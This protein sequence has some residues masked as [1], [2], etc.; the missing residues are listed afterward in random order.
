MFTQDALAGKHALICGASQGIGQAC[1]V[2]MARAGA[3]ITVLARQAAGLRET[4]AL[5]EGTRSEHRAVCCDTSELEQVQRAIKEI[6]PDVDILLCNSGGPAPGPLQTAE[7]AAL[8]Q[9]YRQ[10]V[11]G[12]TLFVQ[13]FAPHMR[14]MHY[15]RVIN[16]ISTSVKVPLPN[17]GVSNTVR[18]AVASWAK[19]LANELGPHGITVNNVLPGYTKTQ[20]LAQIVSNAVQK[21]GKTREAV[22]QGFLD[23]VPA[24]RFAEA[25]EIAAACTF[26]ASPAAAYI[27]G[28]NL[29]VDGGRTGCL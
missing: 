29:P 8:E 21:S 23:D 20:R 27:N 6:G 17:L 26:L 1:A 4:L 2:A 7:T 13:A 9:A 15:G 22:E 3:R 12:P 16:I 11:L 24:R 19:T 25:A 5:L 10:H 28:I 18:G 14:A